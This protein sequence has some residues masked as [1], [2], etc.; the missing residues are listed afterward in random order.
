MVLF[1]NFSR[2]LLLALISRVSTVPVDVALGK[3]ITADVTCGTDGTEEYF[4]LDQEFVLPQERVTS[5]CFNVTQQAARLM[6]D[7]NSDTWWQSTA[8][9]RLLQ[10]GFGVND[11]TP[12]ARDVGGAEAR[13]S[14]RPGIDKF[15]PGR[16]EERGQRSLLLV[17]VGAGDSFG[18]SVEVH[19]FEGHGFEGRNFA[20]WASRP[21]RL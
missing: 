16:C 4:G 6:V 3:P 19:Q 9:D 13:Q 15:S 8:R 5:R 10:R 1:L 7:G 12:D 11:V 20:L 18:P 17:G 21:Q 14:N 2:V